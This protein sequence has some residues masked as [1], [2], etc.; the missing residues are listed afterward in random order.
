MTFNPD[1][2]GE[3]DADYQ[4]A[5]DGTDYPVVV[6]GTYQAWVERAYIDINDYDHCHQLNLMLR[7]VS[8][9]F[10]NAALF[11]RQSFNPQKIIKTAKGEWAPIEFLKQTVARLGLDPVPQTAVEVGAAVGQMLDRILEVK[12]VANP[13]RPE[14]P[15]VY[16]QRFVAMLNDPP[17]RTTANDDLDELGF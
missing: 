6:P 11:V 14:Y 15:K 16:V 17:E 3:Y 10:A 13:T 8:G 4:N 7:V 12:V 2:L 1:E 9:E 5:P